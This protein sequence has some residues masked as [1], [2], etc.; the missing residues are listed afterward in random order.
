MGDSLQNSHSNHTGCVLVVLVD[1]L[2]PVAILLLD[3]H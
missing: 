2:A 3:P 1:V